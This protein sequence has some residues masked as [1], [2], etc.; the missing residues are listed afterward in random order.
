M[1]KS[2]ER[3]GFR[4]KTRGTKLEIIDNDTVL[5][6]LSWILWIIQFSR[7]FI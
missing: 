2:W 6:K 1:M 5:M 3:G 4:R 7:D